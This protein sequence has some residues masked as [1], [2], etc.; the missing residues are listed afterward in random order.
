MS[1]KHIIFLLYS[2]YKRIYTV[3]TVLLYFLFYPT[4]FS[5]SQTMAGSIILLYRSRFDLTLVN[6]NILLLLLLL[7]HCI[8]Y[9][10]IREKILER[11][12][13]REKRGLIEH[14]LHKTSLFVSL[15]FLLPKLSIYCLYFLLLSLLVPFSSTGKQQKC[16][17]VKQYSVNS[18]SIIY[19]F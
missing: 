11:E 19:R 4:Y 7:L 17:F 14:M 6:D 9:V 3:L 1:I 8:S 5:L 2:F 10:N 16:H 18:R 15:F 13:K 12:R